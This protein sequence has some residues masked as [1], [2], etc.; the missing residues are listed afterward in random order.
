[1]SKEREFSLP[2]MEEILSAIK[3][4][5]TNY[6]D[7]ESREEEKLTISK[8]KKI[9]KLLLAISK[10]YPFIV[11]VDTVRNYEKMVED[12]IFFRRI[13][14]GVSYGTDKI[15]DL[16]THEEYDQ[17]KVFLPNITGSTTIDEI[18]LFENIA[19]LES[20]IFINRQY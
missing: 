13:M 15:E 10:N 6:R 16:L 12:F 8:C 20:E 14:Q 9:Q 7:M 11:E 1:M 19:N 5:L 3:K 17:L 2:E 4:A 18:T